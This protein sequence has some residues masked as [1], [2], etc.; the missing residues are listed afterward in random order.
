MMYCNTCK[1]DL[2]D[3]HFN[4][5]YRHCRKCHDNYRA[6]RKRKAIQTKATCVYF[7]R[8]NDLI[9]IGYTGDLSKRIISVQVNNPTIVEVLKTIPGGY[10]EEQQL[11]KKFA[12][13]NKTGE[14]FYATQELLDFIKSDI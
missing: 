3:D 1:K 10:Q 2:P 13:L 4:G 12:H 14:W 7:I 9:K 8:S 11:H 6:T 5:N